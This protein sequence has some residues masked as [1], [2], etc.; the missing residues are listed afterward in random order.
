MAQLTR[1]E[2]RRIVRKIAQR[3]GS[4]TDEDRE[5][6]PPAVLKALQNVR[7]QLASQR[8]LWI[9][10]DT[11]DVR[12]DVVFRLI[13]S[14]RSLRYT[15]AEREGKEPYFS[16]DVSRNRIVIKT[17]DDGCQESDIEELSE[18]RHALSND[19]TGNLYGAVLSY[20]ARISSEVH[21]QSGPFSFVLKPQS[22]GDSLGFAIPVNK[23]PASLPEGVRSR[24]VLYPLLSRGFEEL[25]DEFEAIANNGIVLLNPDDVRQPMCKKFVFQ[26]QT[27]RLKYKVQL[28]D[29]VSEVT[30]TQDPIFA[31]IFSHFPPSVTKRFLLYKPTKP[32]PFDKTVLLF[33]IDEDSRP[34]IG[35]QKVYHI[36]GSFAFPIVGV[37]LKVSSSIDVTCK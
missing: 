10:L 29:G 23:E 32:G 18:A 26:T 22:K 8:T 36:V 4:I 20:T 28:R 6:T 5:A 31:G 9:P 30:Q 34:V 33:P 25:V 27:W 35:F 13:S 7:N 19:S 37:R 2:A 16:L 3:N 24:I 1:Q 14:A 21:V 17:N 12:R 15:R 11:P